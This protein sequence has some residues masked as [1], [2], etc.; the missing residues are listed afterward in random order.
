MLTGP[1]PPVVQAVLAADGHVCVTISG[2][3]DITTGPELARQLARLAELRP[4]ALCVDLSGVT[5]LD[6]ASARL[7]AGT[8]ALVPAGRPPLLTA[9]QPPVR[10]LLELLGLLTILRIAD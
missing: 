7:L 9:V 4:A 10:R 1:P 8:A 3:L 5:F 2:D 6:C